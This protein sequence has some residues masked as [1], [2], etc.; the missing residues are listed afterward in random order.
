MDGGNYPCAGLRQAPSCLPPPLQLDEVA[1]ALDARDFKAVI[2]ALAALRGPIDAF[3]DDVMVMDEDL[4][5]RE[6]RLRLLN[7]F[8]S[9]F[10][11]IANI[12][13]M[14]RK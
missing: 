9:V 3:F 13:E 14:A 6:N 4:A 2:A 8:E 1:S 12:G 5:V 11:G 7:R 10:A